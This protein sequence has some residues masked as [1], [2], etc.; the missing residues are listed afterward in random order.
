MREPHK[1]DV[2]WNASGFSRMFTQNVVP[3]TDANLLRLAVDLNREQLK[4][5]KAPIPSSKNP[6][7]MSLVSQ[8]QATPRHDEVARIFCIQALGQTGE[9]VVLSSLL[10]AATSRS[11]EVRKAVAIALAN[12]RHPLSAY[13]LLP[14]LHDDSARVRKTAMRALMQLG[15]PNTA[16]SI[17]A[18]AMSDSLLKGVF[19]ESLQQLDLKQQRSL[20][21]AFS[22]ATRSQPETESVPESLKS[23][24]SSEHAMSLWENYAI[25]S[26][27][28]DDRGFTESQIY[29]SSVSAQAAD[30]EYESETIESSDDPESGSEFAGSDD[31][32]DDYSTDENP[33]DTDDVAP[34]I[35]TDHDSSWRTY[36]HKNSFSGAGRSK[37]RSSQSQP[38]SIRSRST[39]SVSR[40]TP[41]VRTSLA[42]ASSDVASESW[43]AI[44]PTGES[45][46]NGDG[47][48]TEAN[49]DGTEKKTTATPEQSYAEWIQ[50]K[51]LKSRSITFVAALYLHVLLLLLMATV[52]LAAPES[53]A[54]FSFDGVFSDEYSVDEGFVELSEAEL[55]FSEMDLTSIN[56]ELSDMSVSTQMPLVAESSFV[57][58][59]DMFQSTG[60]G[61]VQAAVAALDAGQRNAPMK[62]APAGAIS[63][64]SFSVW[65][66]PD[67]P[68][69]G[70]P[71]KIVIQMRVP[72]GTE[73]YSITDLEGVVVGSDG[74]QKLIPG[75]LKGFLPVIDGRVQME[76]HIVSA[77][78]NVEDTVFIRSRLLREAQRLQIRF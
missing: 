21:D 75:G 31:L 20:L 77:D 34:I 5:L 35:Q 32:T 6:S 16:E 57:A 36:R 33:P 37:R 25:L 28:A 47:T 61:S 26:Q 9:P 67:N 2:S 59:P 22:D 49:N 69:P 12:V 42:F 18:A 48:L 78:E 4:E 45:L 29:D 41:T 38:V 7:L 40:R 51:I 10:T 71:Y 65:T 13:L 24:I 23:F 60:Q 15:Q 70:E 14:M 76:V 8:L 72:D 56:P 27:F 64:G 66:V 1:T 58:L 62:G 46:L 43:A 17:L 19:Q 53:F 30:S 74:Y 54:P 39:L 52:Y 44:D 63:A 73:E 11:K 3:I 55:D 50:E 68:D